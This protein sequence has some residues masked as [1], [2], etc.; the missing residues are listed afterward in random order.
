MDEKLVAKRMKAV[1]DALEE[2][3]KGVQEADE[4]A[5]QAAEA[6]ERSRAQFQKRLKEMGA[7]SVEVIRDRVVVYFDD[8]ASVIAKPPLGSS[9]GYKEPLGR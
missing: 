6:K 1:R 7:R 9:L 8:G 4:L 5:H 2:R 3:N